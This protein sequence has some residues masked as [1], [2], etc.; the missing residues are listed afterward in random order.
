MGQAPRKCVY[1]LWC[2]ANELEAMHSLISDSEE[3]QGHSL[4]HAYL[5]IRLWFSPL[6]VG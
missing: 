3:G 1:S 6:G 5:L 2:E 4:T